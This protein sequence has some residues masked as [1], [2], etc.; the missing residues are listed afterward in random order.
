MMNTFTKKEKLQALVSISVLAI[1]IAP[2]I[3]IYFLG[4]SLFGPSLCS[5][6]SPGMSREEKI[7]TAVNFSNKLSSARF[8]IESPDGHIFYKLAKQKPY[9]N[10]AQIIEQNPECCKLYSGVTAHTNQPSEE[11]N[12]AEE[13]VVY[14]EYSGHYQDLQ[15]NIHPGKISQFI[16][17]NICKN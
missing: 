15:G 10:P 7:I 6:W 14:V 12:P 4:Y 17:F 8:K 9:K 1:L 3:F 5:D 2:F 16:D 11:I 13:G